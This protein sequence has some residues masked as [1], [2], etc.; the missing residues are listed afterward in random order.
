MEII[1]V[2]YKSSWFVTIVFG[3]GLLLASF[4]IFFLLPLLALQENSFWFSLFH[5]AFSVVPF[6]AFFI[7]IL[8][9]WLWNTFGK[10]VLEYDAEKIIVTKKYKLFN[11]PKTYYRTEIQKIDVE[12]FKIERT[13]YNL[14]YHYSWSDSTFSVVFI[15]NDLPVR[16]VDWI[17]YEKANKIAEQLIL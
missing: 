9:F 13:K 11:K 17:T 3:F 10:T 4:I 16:I 8:Y 14:R 6:L 7:L 1:K 15:C 12:D 2:K 5:Y